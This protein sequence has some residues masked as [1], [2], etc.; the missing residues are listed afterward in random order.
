MKPIV[1]SWFNIQKKP[2]QLDLIDLLCNRL[3]LNALNGI[4]VS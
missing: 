4:D 3:N 2:P 1:L